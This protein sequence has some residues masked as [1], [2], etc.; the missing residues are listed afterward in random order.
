M[1]SPNGFKTQWV[2]DLHER[3]KWLSLPKEG[4]KHWHRWMLKHVQPSLN[5]LIAVLTTVRIHPLALAKQTPSWPL[6]STYASKAYVPV[7]LELLRLEAM[8]PNST[9]VL[10]LGVDLAVPQLVSNAW[11]RI[12][13][14]YGRKK[15]TMKKKK[16]AFEQQWAGKSHT[17]FMTCLF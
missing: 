7:T 10:K 16:A 13:K 15:A 14:A 1:P 3:M 9:V 5:K 11:A 4:Q 6:S 17:I 2:K 8:V 12:C